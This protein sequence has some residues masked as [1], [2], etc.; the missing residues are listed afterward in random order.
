[1]VN[2]TRCAFL[3]FFFFMSF[4]AL[5]A[6]CPKKGIDDFFYCPP[7]KRRGFIG[8]AAGVKY[9]EKY[10]PTR[11][12]LNHQLNKPLGQKKADKIAKSLGLDKS[13]CF[14]E[15]QYLAFITGQGDIL[16]TLNIRNAKITSE[17]NLHVSQC[18]IENDSIAILSSMLKKC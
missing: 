13:L 4:N 12:V 1:M 15:Q 17:F 2:K 9:L 7:K 3:L 14:T 6:Y 10:A 18:L 5:D 11:I 16:H 8:G